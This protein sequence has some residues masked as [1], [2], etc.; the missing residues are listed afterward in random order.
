MPVDVDREMAA[1]EAMTLPELRTRYAEL[2]GETTRGR[3]RANLLRRQ[4]FGHVDRNSL[5]AQLARGFSAGVAHDDHVIFRGHNRLAKAEFLDGP[6]H[7]IDGP[8][9]VTGIAVVRNHVVD[10]Y[11]Y[12]LHLLL[13]C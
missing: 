12:D 6:G 8:V 11:G 7:G 5:Q 10:R 9:V 4:S 3:H 13:L 1:L 2:F